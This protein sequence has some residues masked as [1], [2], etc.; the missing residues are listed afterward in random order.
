MLLGG[1]ARDG[2][3][4]QHIT[5]AEVAVQSFEDAA[6]PATPPQVPSELSWY[7]VTLPHIAKPDQPFGFGQRGM[8]RV[9]VRF[10]PAPT[11]ASDGHPSAVT[12]AAF[13]ASGS[14]AVLYAGDH[15]AGATDHTVSNGFNAP[16]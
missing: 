3:D 5:Q 9:W 11:G 2:A 6:M 4:L 12:Y 1:C 15:I 13:L 16:V 14:Q 8:A 10:T 7:A